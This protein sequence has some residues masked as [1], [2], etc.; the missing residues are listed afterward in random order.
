MRYQPLDEQT[1][2]YFAQQIFNANTEQAK[3]ALAIMMYNSRLNSLNNNDRPSALSYGWLLHFLIS[4][5]GDIDLSEVLAIQNG[6][7]NNHS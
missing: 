3:K 5:H 2:Y 6:P 7:S 1:Y 4:E